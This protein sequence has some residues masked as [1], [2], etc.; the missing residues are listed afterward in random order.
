[1]EGLLDDEVEVVNIPK[2]KGV[3]LIALGHPN[4]GRM[5]FNLAV[6]LKNNEPDLQ[7]ALCYT[8]S[9][10]T[11]LKMYGDDN[12][13][14]YFD[15][16]TECPADIYLTGKEKPDYLRAKAYMDCLT[17]FDD[18]LFL[19]ADMLALP[20]RKLLPFFDKLGDFDMAN[21]GYEYI[22]DVPD[23]AK[24]KWGNAKDIKDVYKLEAMA[25]WYRANSVFVK[26]VKGSEK[27]NKVFRSV[28][29]I[30][31]APNVGHLTFAGNVADELAFEIAM[32]QNNVSLSE[33]M[34]S[35][36]RPAIETP[37]RL[38]ELESFTFYSIAGNEVIPDMKEGYDTLAK[39]HFNKAGLEY[40]Y[41]MKAKST[42]LPERQIY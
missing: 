21:Y 22:K 33:L 8:P 1:M 16:M 19:D 37:L 13:N 40:P 38:N 7:I 31:D 39:W 18:T 35:Y 15:I 20:N 30:Y 14:K 6:S 23:D 41:L 32:M 3:L 24:D 2:T 11:H 4:Y 27:A 29:V 34:P 36:W 26:W 42:Y 17:P 9:A 28:E 10:I 12:I 5:A 25:K